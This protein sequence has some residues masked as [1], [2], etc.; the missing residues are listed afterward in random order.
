MKEPTV[1]RCDF[2]KSNS[3]TVLVGNLDAL[4]LRVALAASALSG[5][6]RGPWPS[7]SNFFVWFIG[8]LDFFWVL[9]RF[10]IARPLHG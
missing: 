5:T 10:H 3:T 4:K 2:Q 9:N 6:F 1:L 7:L 8:L